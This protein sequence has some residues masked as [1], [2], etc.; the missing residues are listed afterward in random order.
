MSGD[1]LAARLDDALALCRAGAYGEAE[2]IYR[3][4]TLA[5]RDAPD[6]WN[7][8]AVVLYQ[9]G[10]LEEAAQA[11]ERATALRPQIAPYWLMRGNIELA[12]KDFTPAQASFT[13]ATALDPA[14]AEAHYRLGL[15]HHG[16]FRYGEAESA[17]RAAL[18]HAPEVAEIHWQLAEALIALGRI[19]E[20]IRAYQEAFSRDSAGALDRRGAFDWLRRLHFDSLPAFWHAELERFFGRGDIDVKPYVGAGLKALKTKAAFDTVLAKAA[21]DAPLEF[22]A[23]LK[24]ALADRLFHALLRDCLM[25]DRQFEHWLTRLRERLLVD[26]QAR[27]QAP[28]DFLCAFALQNLNNEYVFFESARESAAVAALEHDVE[29]GLQAN[30]PASDTTLRALLTLACYRRL[31]GVSGIDSVLQQAHASPAL[32]RLLQ[33]SVIDPRTEQSLRGEIVSITETRDAV[34]REVRGMYEQHPYPRWFAVDREPAFPVSDWIGRELPAVRPVAASHAPRV[35]VAG[36]GTGKD[37][38]WIASNIAN[39]RVLAVDLSLSSLAYGR[40][41]AEALG[42]ANV[43]LRQADI[44]GLSSLEERFDLVASTGVLHHMREP[45]AGLRSVAGLLGPG[46]LMRLG[47]YSARARVS[48][49]AARDL[50]AAEGIHATEPEIRQFRQRVLAAEK[51]SALKELEHSNDFYSMSMCRDLLFHVQEHQFTL[52]QLGE[53]LRALEL[54]FLGLAELTQDTVARYRRLFPEDL[55][56]TDLANWDSY[57]RQYPDTFSGMFVLWCRKAV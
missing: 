36:C 10:A 13:R 29:A 50:I 41:M 46:G 55:H 38:I 51:G 14:F 40:R 1:G 56:M 22:D 26:E 52:P 5:H 57:E 7:M 30:G 42:V 15:A 24:T 32:S 53:M 35:L 9:Q 21:G 43:E 34:S 39:A 11:A 4:L 20:A 37:A 54:E 49:T 2:T 18:R 28:L 33:R 3:G 47:F 17:Y 48:V 31:D 8:L 25:A 12:R 44:L 19:D 23:S 16:D 27:F 45:M 6:A